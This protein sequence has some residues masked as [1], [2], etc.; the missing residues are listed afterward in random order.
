M[1][2]DCWRSLRPGKTQ[3]WHHVFRHRVGEREKLKPSCAA[4]KNQ[5]FTCERLV[6]NRWYVAEKHLWYINKY[7]KQWEVEKTESPWLGSSRMSAMTP[8][9]SCPINVPSNLLRKEPNSRTTI[10]VV[11]DWPNRRTYT[12]LTCIYPAPPA[13]VI[14]PSSTVNVLFIYLLGISYFNYFCAS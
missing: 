14:G 3:L 6:E 11:P 7:I 12:I 10:G 8:L 5:A 9:N 13:T 1:T 2:A 4:C